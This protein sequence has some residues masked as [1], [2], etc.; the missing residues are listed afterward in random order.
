MSVEAGLQNTP[1]WVAKGYAQGSAGQIATAGSFLIFDVAKHLQ[2]NGVYAPGSIGQFQFYGNVEFMNTGTLANGTGDFEVVVFFLN[3]NLMATENGST[4]T[5]PSILSKQMVLDSASQPSMKN[6]SKL[7]VMA[8]GGW[9]DK[10]ARLKYKKLLR[11]AE[12]EKHE[13]AGRSAGGYSAGGYS[14]GSAKLSRR[15]K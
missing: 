15:L 9:Y 3:Q 5:F 10:S 4:A 2:L 11:E 13:G 12:A 14:A 1:W 8:G 6:P 7:A